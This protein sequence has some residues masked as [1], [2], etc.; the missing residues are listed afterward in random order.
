[1]TNNTTANYKIEIKGLLSD[2]WLARLGE[3]R[4]DYIDSEKNITVLSG[5]VKD[6]TE[7]YGILKTLYDLHLQILS[8][9]CIDS[10][11]KTK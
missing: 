11:E 6:Q 8:V 3:M 5:K 7:L 4:Q 9:K 2:K 10:E 1:M